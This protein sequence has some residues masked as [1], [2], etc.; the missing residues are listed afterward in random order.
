MTPLKSS[1]IAG[2]DYDEATQILTVNFQNGTTYRYT[3]VPRE[4]FRDLTLAESAGKFF[5]DNI[6]SVFTG[7]RMGEES[8]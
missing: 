6:R 8:P 3:D 2:A 7:T 5:I 4:V 1:V